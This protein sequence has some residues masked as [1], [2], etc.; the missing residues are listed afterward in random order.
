MAREGSD[1]RPVRRSDTGGDEVAPGEIATG[2]TVAVFGGSFDPPHV[3][4]T[5]VAAYVLSAH[6]VD[7]LLIIPAFRH[8]FAKRLAPYEQR[9][10]MCE[11][12]MAD[13]R[14]V[15]VSRLE[16]EIG[17]ES[18]T[19]RT[20]QELKRRR[21]TANLRLVMGSDLLEETPRWHDFEQIERLAPPIVVA[22]GGHAADGAAGP[23]FPEMSSTE[24]RRR[25]YEGM[26]TRGWLADAVSEHIAR[27]ELYRE[28][29]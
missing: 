7:R 22:R 6:R 3:V 8:P 5:L 19:V 9:V 16:Q 17:G 14:R 11:L 29:P 23:A 2:E 20:L 10:R 15:E 24:I 18:L 21:S 1:A 27:H 26:D 4:H 12:A 25:L 28:A 13:I